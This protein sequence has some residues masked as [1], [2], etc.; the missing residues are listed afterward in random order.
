MI[1]DNKKTI[2]LVEDEAIIAIVEKK[3][4][5]KFGY[6][7]IIANSGETGISLCREKKDIDLVLM[8][9]NLGS[10]MDGTEAAEIILKERS[11]PVV[12]LSSHTEP[13]IV[14][15]TEKITSYGYVVKNSGNTVLDASIKMAFKLF[16]VNNQKGESEQRY[17]SLFN[18]M[19]EGFALHDI[20]FDDTGKP[21]DYR[22]IN[23]NPAFELLTGLKKED[24]IGKSQREVLP[25]ED[26]YWLQ[27]YS[28]V[29]LSGEPVHI[30]HYSHVLKKHYG[31]FAYSPSYG[32]FAVIFSDIT[33]RK[34]AEEELH[35]KNED[36][37]RLNN[38]L[39]LINVQMESANRE[40][41][42]TNESLLETDKKLRRTMEV[43][44]ESEERFRRMFEDGQFGIVIVNKDFI[45]EDVNPAFCSFTGYTAEELKTMSFRDITHPDN[46]KTDI[47]NVGRLGR[48]EITL[49]QTEKKY[50]RKNGAIV[51][52][53]LL[54]S[55]IHDK[56]KKFLYYLSAIIDITERKVAEEALR[57]S[58]LYFENLFNFASAPIILLD[59]HFNIIR[60]NRASEA[61]TGRSA[62]DVTGK[63]IEILFPRDLVGPSMELIHKT[64][65][66]EYIE[67]AEINVLNM[68]G[69]LRTIIWNF[70][71]MFSE[72]TKTPFAI[73]AQGQDITIRKQAEAALLRSEQQFK[74]LV[75]NMQVGV[76]LQG[77]KAEIF[78][79][80]PAALDL[81]GLSEEQL[82]GKTSFDPDWNVI[83][84]DG[85]PFQ[86]HEH[87]VPMA[88]ATGKPVHKVI[89]GVYRPSKNDR[90]WL[91]VDAEPQFNEDQTLRWVICTFIDISDRKTAEKKV[92]KLLEEK[93]I[94]LKEVHHRIRNFMNTLSGLL[95]LQ[96]GSLKD[97]VAIS[98]LEDTGARVR[99]MMVLY[100]KLYNSEDF[101]KV[102]AGIYIPSMADEIISNFPHGEKIKTEKHVDDFL[103]EIK[104]MQSLGIIINELLTNIVKH[105]FPHGAGG[106][107]KI[108]AKKQG[109]HITLTIRDNG[110]G[111]PESVDFKNSSGFGM[112][113][114]DM[115]TEQLGGTIRIE[116]GDGTGFVLDFDL[117][118]G[119][120]Q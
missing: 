112:Q 32:Q 22:F 73:I 28:Q 63:P 68:D 81:L 71:T 17:F 27:T 77:R 101:K 12:F 89:M 52:G 21:V 23:V 49:Y 93:E 72:S 53:N 42:I 55:A 9:I 87:P 104:R 85:S 30:E 2:L 54:V 109:K 84:E 11:L 70:T 13:E 99:S 114:V 98:A 10:G 41:V 86:G 75:W 50:I 79:S 76:I 26:P 64:L 108:S 80:N 8:D 88:I 83:R 105:A 4:L 37:N 16:D 5:E 111:I 78:L 45:F 3:T 106:T 40:L 56:S 62:S 95:A 118:T 31:V 92:E 59:P 119:E 7:V 102:S 60:F 47:E 57:Q 35:K 116:R 90:V 115:L 36:L 61:V 38:D 44:S 48:G 34:I 74:N 107:V 14:E 91:L 100:D 46:L 65:T 39:N 51:W 1:S 43:L 69:T 18:R 94:L 25:E 117:L 58:N 97:P 19:T 33:D 113:L 103:L 24:L 29:A 67:T 15:K 6:N 120:C 66:S 110:K 82:L 20:I 96:A